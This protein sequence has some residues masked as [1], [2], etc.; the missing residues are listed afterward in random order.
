MENGL[1]RFGRDLNGFPN[2]V[3]LRTTERAERWCCHQ[4]FSEDGGIVSGED[5]GLERVF[6]PMSGFHELWDTRE[7]GRFRLDLPLAGAIRALEVQSPTF[8]RG[9]RRESSPNAVTGGTSIRRRRAGLTRWCH[10]QAPL[11][12]WLA[13][14]WRSW[15]PH[16]LAVSAEAVRCIP[17]FRPDKAGVCGA[18]LRTRRSGDR[19]PA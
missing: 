17:R 18:A 10:G 19:L 8:R 1:S 11:V 12:G 15:D 6:C 7:A 5:T 16:V 14:G 3:A 4:A 13:R 2:A 9:L